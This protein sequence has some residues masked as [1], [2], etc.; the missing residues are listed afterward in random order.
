MSDY[1]LALGTLTATA[2]LASSANI[3][4]NFPRQTDQPQMLDWWILGDNDVY[5][6]WGAVIDAHNGTRHAQGSAEFEWL[7]YLSPLMVKYLRDTFFGQTI[8]SP[9][10]LYAYVTAQ[11]YD[12]TLGGEWRIVNA[13]M[14]FTEIGELRRDGLWTYRFKFIEAVKAAA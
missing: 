10:N 7:L 4:E 13:L 2:L 12:A 9:G 5:S 14:I 6:E 3:V 1:R 11:T 8:S